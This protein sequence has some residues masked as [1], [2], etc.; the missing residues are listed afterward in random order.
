[1]QFTNDELAILRALG[2]TA[3]PTGELLRSPREGTYRRMERFFDGMPPSF[4]QG[5][6]ALLWTLELRTLASTGAR[7][8]SMPSA[9]RLEVLDEWSASEALR[10]PLRGLLAPIK[11]AHF[12]DPQVYAAIGCRYGVE[13]PTKLEHARWREQIS[14][15]GALPDGETL[16]CDVVVVGSGAGGAPVAKALAE[17]GHAVLV[18]E[19]GQHHTRLDFDGRPL[20][21]LQKTY[22]KNGLTIAYGNTAIPIPVG[23][24]VG[25]TTTINSG[26]CFRLPET[27]L[28]E[29][30]AQYGLTELTSASLAPYYD[31]CERFMEVGPSS[32]A[33]LGKPA[34]VIAKGCDA[35]GYSHHALPRNAPGCDG[36]GLCCFGCPTDAKR[37][38]NISWVPSALGAG[39]QLLTGFKVERV[40]TEGETAVGVEGTANGPNGPVKLTVRA[41]VVVLACGTLYTPLLLLKSGLANGSGQ[42]GRNLSIHPASGALGLFG[43]DLEAWKTVPQGYAIDEFRDEGLMFEGAHTPLDVTAATLTTYGP[44]FVARM[45]QYRRTVGFG[46]MV[47]DR[48]RGRVRLGA[49]GEPLLS[50][51]L[52]KEDL[53]TMMRGFGI[54]ARVFFAAGATAVFPSIAF[55]ERLA[56]LADV[57]A[58][59]RAHVAPR[60]L[61][62]SAYHPLGTCR[63]GHDP[64]ASVVDPT[65]ETH[66]VHNLFVCDG[67][68]VPGSL[69]VNPQLTIMALALRAAESIDRRIGVLT[70]R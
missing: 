36:Q 60:H 53:A 46:F 4:G 43:E 23:L 24:G 58:L 64:F 11:M 19:E 63:M 26:T 56:S 34:E 41:R 65:H 16:E 3:L 62:I 27:T 67:S 10:L 59:E 6:R 18:L 35:L 45:E 49:H 42:V 12:D 54:L 32:K 66:D 28:A 70:A 31:A 37:S 7:F 69:G 51:W 50:Y 22:R 39:A 52:G 8:S 44:D 57:E 2:E 9:R 38:A 47:K 29:W 61:D 33:A 1:M 68:V 55:H 13:V 5:Y 20:A 30:H 17:R 48:S 40:L 25:G 15:A 14:D 21:M